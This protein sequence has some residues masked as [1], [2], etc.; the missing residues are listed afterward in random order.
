M[1][2]AVYQHHSDAVFVIKY[3][4]QS[5]LKERI[6]LGLQFQNDTVCHDREE[7]GGRNSKSSAITQTARKQSRRTGSGAGPE[8]LEARPK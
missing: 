4:K 7:D 5:T 1:K 2:I 6:Y 3:S 8:N